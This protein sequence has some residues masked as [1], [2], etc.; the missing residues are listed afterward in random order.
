M[1]KKKSKKE[2][3]EIAKRAWDTRRKKHGKNG[4]SADGL[5]RIRKR[6]AR[7]RR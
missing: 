7:K 2:L 3:S 4:I 1:G 6:N 5:R